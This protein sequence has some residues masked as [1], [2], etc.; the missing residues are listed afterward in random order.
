[1]KDRSD[2]PSHHERTLL[3]RR[4]FL[5]DALRDG[6]MATLRSRDL[7]TRAVVEKTDTMNDYAKTAEMSMSVV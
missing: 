4:Y 5:V 6:S 3:P 1:M 7:E 2:D